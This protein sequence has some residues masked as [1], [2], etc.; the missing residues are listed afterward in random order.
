M[1]CW[2]ENGFGEG[3][4]GRGKGQHQGSDRKGIIRQWNAAN[5]IDTSKGDLMRVRNPDARPPQAMM[6]W[7]KQGLS[8]VH[9]KEEFVCGDFSI[10]FFLQLL[11]IL[12]DS[13]SLETS[14]SWPELRMELNPLRKK[15][16]KERRKMHSLFAIWRQAA[17]EGQ[18]PYSPLPRTSPGPQRHRW[19]L[20]SRL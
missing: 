1:L 7:S 16:R 14:K 12:R 15:G 4:L 9:R 20:S 6:N 8:S 13:H 2:S 10:P 18:V 17:S 3:L 19:Q 5:R 11:R